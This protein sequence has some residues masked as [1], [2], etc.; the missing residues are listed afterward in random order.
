MPAWLGDELWNYG[1]MA[2]TISHKHTD[3]R[4]A[5]CG[6]VKWEYLDWL[7]PGLGQ[8]WDRLWKREPGRSAKMSSAARAAPAP[9]T[10]VAPAALSTPRQERVSAVGCRRQG[11]RVTQGYSRLPRQSAELHSTSCSSSYNGHF[12]LR[13]TPNILRT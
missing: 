4:D 3:R 10:I 5:I 7:W 1:V 9:S 11:L 6:S 8:D 12:Q 13:S 2:G